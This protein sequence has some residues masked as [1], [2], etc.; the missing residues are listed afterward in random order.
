MIKVHAFF[1]RLFARDIM[2]HILKPSLSLY[3][4]NV[5]HYRKAERQYMFSN[6]LS[7]YAI[8]VTHYR[9]TMCSFGPGKC[10]VE[11][12]RVRFRGSS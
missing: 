8:N 10:G 3:V 2:I 9:Y 12:S 4:I 11:C 5:T 6:L 1:I 7:L